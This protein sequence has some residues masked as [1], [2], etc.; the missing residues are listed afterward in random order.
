MSR[1]NRNFRL[2]EV[3][4]EFDAALLEAKKTDSSVDASKFLRYCI[5]KALNENR[6]TMNPDE[7]KKLIASL[8]ELKKELAKVGGNLNQIAHYFNT[9]QHLI[10]TDLHKQH[11]ALQQTLKDTGFKLNEVIHGIGRSTY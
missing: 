3:E 2:N 9:H 4:A 5:K 7:A 8:F 6:E 11:R 10:E 1:K